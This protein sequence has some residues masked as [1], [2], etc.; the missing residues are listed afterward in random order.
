L[1]SVQGDNETGDKVRKKAVLVVARDRDPDSN[2]VGWAN[3]VVA[4]VPVVTS[5]F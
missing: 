1:K 3:R 2:P 5:T 4:L